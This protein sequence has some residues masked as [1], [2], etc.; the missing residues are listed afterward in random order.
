MSRILVIETAGN[1]WGSERALLDLLEAMDKSEVAVC[2]PPRRPLRTELERR[3]FTVFPHFVYALHLRPRWRRLQA[4][5][6]VLRACAAFGPDVLYLNQSGSYRVAL[7]AARLLGLPIA[8]HIRIFEDADYLG[9]LNPSPTRLRAVIA[10][11][12]AVEHHVRSLERLAEIPVHAVYDGYAPTIHA[13]ADRPRPQRIACVGRLVPI[14]GQD[15]LIE[16]MPLLLHRRPRAE[17]VMAGDGEPA[18][19]ADLKARAGQAITWSGFI[20]D[21]GPLLSQAAVLACPSHREPL[22]RVIFEAWDAGAVPVVF[23]GSGGAAEIVR[24]ADAGVVYDRQDPQALAEALDAALGLEPAERRRLVENGRAW[25]AEHCDPGRYAG[26]IAGVLA[27][28]AGQGV[29]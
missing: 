12:K 28:A 17:C 3:G 11:S 27:R 19:A 10:I 8:A 14:K 23:A 18:F 13:P 24:A 5:I 20:R 6:G 15:L 22:G 2:C 25:M 7:P 16:A 9:S 29:P 26:V 4:A 1:L 21:I